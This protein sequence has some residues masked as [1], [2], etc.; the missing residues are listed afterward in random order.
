MKQHAAASL[1]GW[2]R[3]VRECWP[4]VSLRL[5]SEA[6]RELPRGGRLQIQI[7][8]ST[9]GLAAQDLRVEFTG[10]RLLPR[11]RTELPPFSSIRSEKPVCG[12]RC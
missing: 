6:P 10:Q 12:G 7:A 9:N 4:G 3:R 1:D 8:A 11:S 5:L 2:K